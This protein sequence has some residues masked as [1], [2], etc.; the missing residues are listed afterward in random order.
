MN[1]NFSEPQLKLKSQLMKLDKE[2]LVNYLVRV[3]D[4]A[5][6]FWEKLIEDLSEISK[7]RSQTRVMNRVLKQIEDGTF[8]KKRKIIRRKKRS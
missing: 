3:N 1:E 6:I 2:V 7:T 5:N 4:Y 8:G